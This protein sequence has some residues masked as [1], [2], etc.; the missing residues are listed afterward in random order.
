MMIRRLICFMA[1]LF[2]GTVFCADTNANGIS[3]Q[4]GTSDNNC[5]AGILEADGHYKTLL[6]AFEMSNMMDLLH[7]S[8]PITLF[9]PSDEALA[10][11]PGFD[12]LNDDS[13]RL[14]NFLKGHIIFGRRL[15]SGD[16][17]TLET[18]VTMN[19]EHLS[20][21]VV[22]DGQ[23]KINNVRLNRPNLEAENGT[24]HGIDG[25]LTLDKK[26]TEDEPV[27]TEELF[28]DR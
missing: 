1:L 12:D 16:F 8:Q 19:G 10:K 4:T 22:D 25:V 15:T 21:S 13:D 26:M 23:W 6:S 5:V 27:I 7:G 9:A 3:S 2:A 18:P 20:F 24:V 28:N 11:M 14:S 17:S